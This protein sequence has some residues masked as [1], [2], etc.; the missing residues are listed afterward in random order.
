MSRRARKRGDKRDRWK[1]PINPKP[2]H[3]AGF[4]FAGR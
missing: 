1:E 2:R 3:R 4:V